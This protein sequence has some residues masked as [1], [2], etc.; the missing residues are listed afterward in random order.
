MSHLSPSVNPLWAVIPVKP[1]HAGKSRLAHLLSPDERA[2]LILGFLQQTLAILTAQAAVTGALVISSDP[3]VLA[4]AAAQGATTHAESGAR[5]LNR[6][7]ADGVETAVLAGATQTLIVPADLPFIQAADVAQLLAA[8]PAEPG[9]T[10]RMIIC[11]D[12]HQQGT[13][14]L[15][16]SPPTRFNFHYGPNS[17]QRHLREAQRLGLAPAVLELPGLQFDLDTEG[18]WQIYQARVGRQPYPLHAPG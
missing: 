4:L 10:P 11:P 16:L 3:A 13:N 1:L 15:L 8:N 17:F 2:R 9:G 7:V 6:A 5:G 12:R 18:D 14:A